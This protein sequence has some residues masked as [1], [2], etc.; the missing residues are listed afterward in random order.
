MDSTFINAFSNEDI[1]EIESLIECDGFDFEKALIYIA[2]C[3]G[4]S[5][6]F[7]ERATTLILDKAKQLWDHWN[8]LYSKLK[9]HQCPILM[10]AV[11]YNNIGFITAVTDRIGNAFW[12]DGG[13]VDWTCKCDV[14]FNKHTF[15]A[16]STALHVAIETQN[17]DIIFELILK[18]AKFWLR[19]TNDQSALE[20]IE[21][22]KQDKPEFLEYLYTDYGYDLA[23]QIIKSSPYNTLDHLHIFLKNGLSTEMVNE[24]GQ[25]LLNTAIE[26]WDVRVVSAL[27]N[28]GARVHINKQFTHYKHKF[29]AILTTPLHVAIEASNVEMVEVLL[30]EGCDVNAQD[31]RHNTPLHLL[32]ELVGWDKNT[33]SI[34]KGIAICRLLLE[35]GSDV[36]AVDKLQRTSLE[37]TIQH[38]HYTNYKQID[39]IL[40]LISAGSDIQRLFNMRKK[41]IEDWNRRSFENQFLSLWW[42]SDFQQLDNLLESGFKFIH[43]KTKP[44]PHCNRIIERVVHRQRNPLTLRRIS[45]NVIRVHLTPNA[46]VG[47]EQLPLGP[48]F[49]RDFITLGLANKSKTKY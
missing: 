1:D 31:A 30:E 28:H 49:D 15:P 44:D 20:K 24:N 2:E 47:R 22:I 48:V 45:A 11:Y 35:Y 7:V 5:S 8:Q 23:M 18:R 42:M 14:T 21:S 29:G 43:L 40:H 16:N 3:K 13:I 26:K 12:D 38:C 41:E 17:E 27:L 25:Y 36:N 32:C 37:I 6:T 19:D 9:A 4:I 46:W 33:Y 34:N 39:M 10:T